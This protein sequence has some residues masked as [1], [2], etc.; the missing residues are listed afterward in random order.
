MSNSN[1]S[2]ALG[3]DLIEDE[4]VAEM[5]QARQAYAA[6]FDYDLERI[7]ADLEH[8]AAGHPERWADVAPVIPAHTPIR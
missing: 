4:I 7:L 2:T 1:D 3:K 5:R 8:K 6:R